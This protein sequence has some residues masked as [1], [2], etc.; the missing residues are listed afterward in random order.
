MEI[1]R[2]EWG[3]ENLLHWVRDV[4]FREDESQLRWG[5]GPEVL[6]ILNNVVPG[7]LRLGLGSKCNIAKARRQRGHTFS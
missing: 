6:A 3:I 7:T 2:E 5:N 4:T 1:A